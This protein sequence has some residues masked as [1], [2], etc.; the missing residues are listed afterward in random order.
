MVPDQ[1]ICLDLRPYSSEGDLAQDGCSLH[2][3]PWQLPF[4]ADYGLR[5]TSDGDRFSGYANLDWHCFQTMTF[6]PFNFS[7]NL[8]LAKHRTPFN[9][10]SS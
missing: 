8:T 5:G 4:R 7:V 3:R 10:S 9:L 2:L 1:L 6:D